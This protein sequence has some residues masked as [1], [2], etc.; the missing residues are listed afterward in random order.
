MRCGVVLTAFYKIKT[1]TRTAPCGLT[2]FQTATA[3]QKLK[4]TYRGA[5]WCGAGGFCGLCGLMIT[6]TSKDGSYLKMT[7][8]V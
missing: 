4:T 6:P 5:V 7:L 3:P 1:A 2:I 8:F